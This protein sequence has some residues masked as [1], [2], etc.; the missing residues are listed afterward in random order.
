MATAAELYE[1]F[2]PKL[3]DA[4]ARVVKD[5]INVLRDKHGLDDRT[6]EQVVN[7]IA[8]KLA[9]IPDYPWMNPDL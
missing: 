8:A 5:E 7:A 3:I 9:A 2:G 1:A 4:L 6:N